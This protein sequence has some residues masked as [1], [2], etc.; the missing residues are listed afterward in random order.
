MKKNMEGVAAAIGQNDVI[1]DLLDLLLTDPGDCAY[2][3]CSAYECLNNVKGRCTIHTV[4][5]RRRILSNGR[6]AEYLI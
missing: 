6:C 3:V 2:I 5:G 4:K 1:A